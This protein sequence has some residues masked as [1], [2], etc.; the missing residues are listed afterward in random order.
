MLLRVLLAAALACGT[1][2][3][4]LR[5]QCS[6]VECPPSSLAS[7]I[8]PSP[9]SDLVDCVQELFTS[10]DRQRFT[11]NSSSDE[12]ARASLGGILGHGEIHGGIVPGLGDFTSPPPT[13]APPSLLALDTGPPGRLDVGAGRYFFVPPFGETRFVKNHVVLLIDATVARE[14]VL[15]IVGLFGLSLITSQEIGLLGKTVYQFQ[16]NSGASV[17]DVIRELASHPI[18][19]GAA[20]DYFY[21]LSQDVAAQSGAPE[22]DASQYVLQ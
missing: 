15:R 18:I 1:A 12:A 20:S 3:A 17:A 21:F 10:S 2:R 7:P 11:Y 5:P 9:R 22:G 8:G 19:D 13:S 14:E 16:I 4:Q 6:D